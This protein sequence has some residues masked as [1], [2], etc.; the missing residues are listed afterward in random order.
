M[1]LLRT[2]FLATALS[3]SLSFFAIA[4]LNPADK[5]ETSPASTDPTGIIT[6]V[7]GSDAT[8]YAGNGGPAIDAAMQ[9]P[10]SVAVDAAGNL[11]IAD[12][13]N[14]VIRLVTAST[15]IISTY[16]GV[17]ET[18][19]F[20]GDGSPATSAELSYPQG[21]ALDRSGNL[22][23]ADSG[24]CLIRRVD[25][26][27]HIITTVAGRTPVSGGYQNENC[28]HTGD[29][30]LATDAELFQPNGVALDPGGDLYIADTSNDS[31][32]RVDAKTHIITTI[33][34]GCSSSAPTCERGFGGD[35]GPAVKAL[36]AQPV[37]VALD[38][39]E[40]LYIADKGNNRIRRID[41]KTGIITTV[42]GSCAV[43]EVDV[44]P[45]GYTPDGGLATRAV[46]AEPQGVIV[47]PFGNIVFSDTE[48]DLVRKID[49]KTGK[50]TTIAGLYGWIG[51]HNNGGPAIN[52]ALQWPTQLA[53]DNSGN[54]YIVDSADEVIRQVT[55]SNQPTAAMPVFTP[56]PGG[57]PTTIDVT[58]SDASK[59][60]AIYYT[61]DGSTPTTS[62]TEY[63]APIPVSASS[64]VIAF[65]TAEG[66]VNSTASVASYVI[67]P[68]APAPVIAPQS[69]TYT[70]P[71]SVTFSDADA[72]V[73]YY[74]TTDGSKP[75]T[76]S[77]VYFGT[78]TLAANTVLKAIAVEQN[79]LPSPVSTAVYT[80]NLPVLPAPVIHPKAGT[81]LGTQTI[82]I[83]DSN[84]NATIYYSTD[85]TISNNN[86]QNYN[87]PFS[88]ANSATVKAFASLYGYAN[89]PVA[90]AAYK[91]DLPAPTFYPNGGTFTGQVYISLSDGTQGATI[92]C[93]IDG[94]IPTRH[95]DLC[96]DGLIVSQTTTVKAM[97]TETGDGDSTVATAT[98]IIQ[99]PPVA[100]TKAPTG[101][102]SNSAQLNGTVNPEDLSTTWWFVYGYTSY[103]LTNKT[104]VH[105]LAP[106][107]KAIT[108]EDTLTGLRSNTGYY[109]QLVSKNALG[110]S[111]GIVRSFRTK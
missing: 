66:L 7:A 20:S 69:G 81:H 1:R 4:Q 70:K 40:N 106:G 53:Y 38:T 80:I 29:G 54:L 64:T 58:I 42:A 59:D 19:G 57:Y 83:S 27:S 56:A 62:S 87:G 35:G 10:N 68:Q 77:N 96:N 24:N 109:F 32:R 74:Y 33:A 11:Y 22:Y 47:D 91:I 48:N 98:Y 82:T 46:L 43:N 17:G 61:L 99:Q 108:G 73:S 50:L 49:A 25:A 104:A 51:L 79:R 97:A 95:S 8:G 34:G 37:A 93:T 90:S 6:I 103:S 14:S 89:S 92:Y 78:L 18:A 94:T 85:G 102:T 15:G 84:R 75:T 105:S 110:T 65:A 55:G 101:I 16:A 76:Q 21:V 39:E 23:I 30:G 100:T 86:A 3:S 5:L 9:W 88:I 44:C 2:A 63:T 26:H 107:S 31:I 60:S 72:D 41:L 71:V 28:N 36:L 52:A 67:E 12:T 111:S 45:S 13:D